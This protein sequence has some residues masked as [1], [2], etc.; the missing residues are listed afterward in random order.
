MQHFRGRIEGERLFKHVGRYGM[1]ILKCVR[2]IG[3]DAGDW[4]YWA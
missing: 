4:T 2:E 1:L 3:W